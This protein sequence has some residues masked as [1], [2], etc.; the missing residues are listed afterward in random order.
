MKY[1][2][3]SHEEVYAISFSIV[4]K[5]FEMDIRDSLKM[6]VHHFCNR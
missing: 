4:V 1:A 6:E 5:Q 3:T 2:N